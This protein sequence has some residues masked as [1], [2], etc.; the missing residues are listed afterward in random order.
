[1][2]LLI[3]NEYLDHNEMDRGLLAV[4]SLWIF[5]GGDL[6]G[7]YGET[8]YLRCPLFSFINNVYAC[9]ESIV[10]LIYDIYKRS[11]Q[12]EFIFTFDKST[13]PE[14]FL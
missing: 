6:T 7:C 13:H 10:P 2:N 14:L 8:D 12:K 9:N 11:N 5:D 1:M 4:D 3:T